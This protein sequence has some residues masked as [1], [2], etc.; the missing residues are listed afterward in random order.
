MVYREDDHRQE[1]HEFEDQSFHI[2]YNDKI[3]LYGVF[4]G[5]D[6]VQFAKY[7]IDTITAEILLELD[8]EKSDKEVKQVLKYNFTFSIIFS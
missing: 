1:D 5:H 6:G 8:G 7:A 4:D 3:S 2:K